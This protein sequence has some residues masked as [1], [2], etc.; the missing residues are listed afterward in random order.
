[1]P[2]RT[3]MKASISTGLRRTSLARSASL[4]SGAATIAAYRPESGARGPVAQAARPSTATANAARWRMGLPGRG[5]RILLQSAAPRARAFTADRA[6]SRLRGCDAQL[7]QQPRRDDL[8]V[9]APIA[10]LR[11]AAH[12]RAGGI[13]PRFLRRA[14]VQQQVEVGDRHLRV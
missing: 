7:S 14:V 13:D 9:D 2:G 12:V 4:R 8:V 3:P 1:M 10:P 11:G 6:D 5:G